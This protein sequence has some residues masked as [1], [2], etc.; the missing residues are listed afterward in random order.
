[1]TISVTLPL[2][3]DIDRLALTPPTGLQWY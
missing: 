1:V 2:G 3:G